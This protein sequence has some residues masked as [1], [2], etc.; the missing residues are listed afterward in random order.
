MSFLERYRGLPSYLALPLAA[1]AALCI[2][3]MVFAISFAI[4]YSHPPVG[5]TSPGFNSLG[6]AFVLA[7]LFFFVVLPNLLMPVFIGTVTAFVNLHHPASWKTP[8]SAF[9]LC[10]VTA[11]LVLA[12]KAPPQSRHSP[13]MLLV[14]LPAGVATWLATCWWLRKRPKAQTTMNL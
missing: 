5:N 2:S 10:L 9:I 11:V 14:M 12:E 6:R 8:T 4:A 13:F 3:G 7:I 1:T